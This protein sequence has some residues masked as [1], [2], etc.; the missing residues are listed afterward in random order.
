[1]ILKVWDEATQSYKGIPAINGETPYIGG[2]GNWWIGGKDTGVAAGGGDVL[3]EDGVIKQEH[4]PQGYPYVTEKDLLEG[5]EYVF[6]EE[7]GA[8]AIVTPVTVPTVGKAYKVTW[9]GTEYSCVAFAPGDDSMIGNMAAIGGEDT[10]E[11]FVMVFYSGESDGMYGAV[12]SLDGTTELS[13]SVVGNVE[14]R[15]DPSLMPS[16]V[17][18]VNVNAQTATYMP[19]KTLAETLEAYESGRAVEIYIE[20]SKVHIRKIYSNEI[21]MYRIDEFVVGDENSY[22]TMMTYVWRNDEFAETGFYKVGITT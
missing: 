2:N 9:N 12:M 11:P 14:N 7:A 13:V 1:M 4:L 21:L 16:P 22:F 6:V 8:F 10:G 5:A 3:G 17:F 20:D 15:M 19:D 18:R